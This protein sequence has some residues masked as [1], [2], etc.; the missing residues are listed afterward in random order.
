MV[1][2]AG[3]VWALTRYYY[4]LIPRDWYRRPPFLPLP[5]AKY[6][7]WRMQTAYGRQR[8]PWHEVLRDLWQFGEWLRTFNKGA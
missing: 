7:Q 4:R 8:P 1:K 5:P 2:Q 3:V 6:V